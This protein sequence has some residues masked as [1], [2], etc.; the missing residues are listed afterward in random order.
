M[1]LRSIPGR[2]P[3]VDTFNHF[4]VAWEKG[5]IEG[6][7]DEYVMKQRKLKKTRT[8]HRDVAVPFID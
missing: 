2:I 1:A 7:R 8:Y 3:F 4:W 5:V 6:G